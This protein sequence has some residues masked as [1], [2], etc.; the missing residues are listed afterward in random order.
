MILWSF[1]ADTLGSI[2]IRIINVHKTVL[3][4]VICTQKKIPEEQLQ[5]LCGG[6]DALLQIC[7][8]RSDQGIAEIPRVLLE[9]VVID[10]KTESFH[11][12]DH[13]NGG[14]TGIPLRRYHIETPQEND[15]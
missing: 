9:G 5:E 15:S 3:Q 13:K 12:L 7:I 2:V 6:V 1:G 11:I 10:T 14:G 8:V 4:L